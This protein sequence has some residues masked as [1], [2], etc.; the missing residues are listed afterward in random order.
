MNGYE[1]G[2]AALNMK[3]KLFNRKLKELREELDS[4]TGIIREAKAKLSAAKEIEGLREQ[5]RINLNEEVTKKN[6][7]NEDESDPLGRDSP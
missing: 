1:D 2:E 5:M 4:R 3:I 6:K 7:E